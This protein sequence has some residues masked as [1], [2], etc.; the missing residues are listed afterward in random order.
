MDDN[1]KASISTL[2]KHLGQQGY[3]ISWSSAR[4]LLHADSEA[5]P[6]GLTKL[7]PPGLTKLD[8]DAIV[9]RTKLTPQLLSERETRFDGS[10]SVKL[11]LDL[12]ELRADIIREARTL[13]ACET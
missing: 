6:S 2:R 1:P 11:A 12:K 10:T 5:D 13:R 7:D 9:F 8:P 3:N 4:R